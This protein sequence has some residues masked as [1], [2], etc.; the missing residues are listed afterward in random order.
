M[1]DLFERFAPAS[2][3]GATR[4]TRVTPAPTICE[5]STL[6]RA[7]AVTHVRRQQR[8]MG[9]TA[10]S[11]VTPLPNAA[12]PWVTSAAVEKAKPE[13]GSSPALSSLPTSP[14]E[15]DGADAATRVHALLADAFE[16]I[17]KW[18]VEGAELPSAELEA[19]ID[20]AVLGRDLGALRVA[21][22]L[23]EQ[24]ARVACEHATE[25]WP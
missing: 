3:T 10:P 19:D 1:R 17:A 21:L 2:Q 13:N 23:Y 18:W 4:A 25:R 11:D 14:T 24:A 16:R 9:N 6:A 7:D 20:R 15:N 5:S 12:P 22:T 8:N